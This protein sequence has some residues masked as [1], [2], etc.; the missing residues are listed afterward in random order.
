MACFVHR[1]YDREIEN[2]KRHLTV[3]A[4]Y[5][6]KQT[7]VTNAHSLVELA[8]VPGASFN[9]IYFESLTAQTQQEDE[10]SPEFIR[11]FGYPSPE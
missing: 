8:E 1:G 11:Y 6:V 7:R 2:A 5:T 4:I 3:G 10:Q 9:T